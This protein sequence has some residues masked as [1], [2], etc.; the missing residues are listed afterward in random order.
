MVLDLLSSTLE[1]IHTSTEMHLLFRAA[2]DQH[3]AEH[4]VLRSSGRSQGSTEHG[5][6]IGRTIAHHSSAGLS[7]FAKE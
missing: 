4:L 7:L 5:G 6:P 1:S 3:A 2:V